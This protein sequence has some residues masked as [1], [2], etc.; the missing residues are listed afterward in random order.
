M[1]V[2]G[3]IGKHGR[4][5]IVGRGANFVLP[6]E[7]RFSVRIVGPRRRGVYKMSQ[8]NFI[9]QLKMPKDGSCEPNQTAGHLFGN[10]L[11]RISLIPPI[12]T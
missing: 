10:I 6:P 2:I 5:V 4:A 7:K 11:T 9:F 12:M 1:K 3:T 8:K